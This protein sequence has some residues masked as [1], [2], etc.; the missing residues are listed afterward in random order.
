MD[1]ERHGIRATIIDLGLARMNSGDDVDAV[2]WTPFE[3]ETFE[4]EGSILHSLPY[5]F[6]TYPIGD[7]QFDIYRMMKVH[8]GDSWEDFRPLSNVMVSKSL[9]PSEQSIYSIPVASLPFGQT[10]TFKTAPQTDCPEKQGYQRI[11][12]PNILRTG[13]LAV[14]NGSRSNPWRGSQGRQAGDKE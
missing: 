11:I 9:R 4:G 8:N 10:N 13:M 14:S 6:L 1:S 5:K 2:H 12:N 7:Y 3:K